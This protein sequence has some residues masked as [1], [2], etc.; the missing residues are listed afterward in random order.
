M[1]NNNSSPDDPFLEAGKQLQELAQGPARQAAEQLE[2]I[3][4]RTGN[5]IGREL[6]K[7]ALSGS[8]SFEK[9]VESILKDLAR[10]AIKQVV[11]SAVSSV[12]GAAIEGGFGGARADGGQVLGGGSYLVGEKGPEVFRP[13]SAGTIDPMVGSSAVTVNFNIAGGAD[14]DGFRRS[15]GQISAMLSRAVEQGRRRL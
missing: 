9:M 15:Q 7:A 5:R 3:F 10:I 11:G 2:E 14:V 13:A 6:E 8:V 1:D 4:A 12:V